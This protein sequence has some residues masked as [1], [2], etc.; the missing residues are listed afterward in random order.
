MLWAKFAKPT[1]EDEEDEPKRPPKRPSRDAKVKATK[2]LK[3]S[4]V[5]TDEEGGSDDTQTEDEDDGADDDDPS[6]VYFS[7]IEGKKVGHV[8]V[9]SG[10]Y[11][12]MCPPRGNPGG[13][14]E[15]NKE[16]RAPKKMWVRLEEKNCDYLVIH[17]GYTTTV[18]LREALGSYRLRPRGGKFRAGPYTNKYTKSFINCEEIIVFRLG[19]VR[20][21]S[22][23]AGVPPWKPAGRT[24]AKGRKDGKGGK[25]VKAE[26]DSSI[27][28]MT[29]EELAAMQ[30]EWV[31]AVKEPLAAELARVMTAIENVASGAVTQKHA[32]LNSLD[33]VKHTTTAPPPPTPPAA[34]VH[35]PATGELNPTG[36]REA[37]PVPSQPMGVH[38]PSAAVS[39]R[40][41]LEFQAFANRQDAYTT[42]LRIMIPN[43]YM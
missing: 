14:P 3:T 5:L 11:E 16:Y 7:I 25:D 8:V 4:L 23:Q 12:V 33:G 18:C 34:V 19:K 36:H 9:D 41:I 22:P 15:K 30:A 26:V 21:L 27:V 35:V 29:K 39:M 43:Y 31:A 28:T 42:Q 17:R 1:I 10:A 38:P 32:I 20:Y 13:K 40:H 24:R 2:K 37:P 6:Q